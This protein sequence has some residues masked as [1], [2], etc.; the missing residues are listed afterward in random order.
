MNFPLPPELQQTLALAA[1][2]RRNW[3]PFSVISSISKVDSNIFIPPDSCGSVLSSG[4]SGCTS[5]PPSGN[6]AAAPSEISGDRKKNEYCTTGKTFF[7]YQRCWSLQT[8]LPLFVW[9]RVSFKWFKEIDSYRRKKL[10]SFYILDSTHKK[11]WHLHKF[12]SSLDLWS[13]KVLC[14]STRW[15]FCLPAAGEG[16]GEDWPGSSVGSLHQTDL[17]TTAATHH[18]ATRSQ[19][20]N[21][22]LTEKIAPNG[23]FLSLVLDPAAGCGG[24]GRIHGGWIYLEDIKGDVNDSFEMANSVKLK[25]SNC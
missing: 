8:A 11:N 24:S 5:A 10:K 4:L 19:L 9:M 1:M 6:A 7:L 20:D 18:L 23:L 15:F 12:F 17:R 14:G 2:R 21:E 16:E 13:P 3:K 22:P 25:S